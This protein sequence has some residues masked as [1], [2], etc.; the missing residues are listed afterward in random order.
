MGKEM[1]PFRMAAAGIEWLDSMAAKHRITRSDVI[2]MCLQY[3][4]EAEED[5]RISRYL[6]RAIQTGRIRAEE[7]S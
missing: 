1:V 4:K 6:T 2:R 3:A 7:E 5:A